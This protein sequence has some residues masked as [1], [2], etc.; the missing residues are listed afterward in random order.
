MSTAY[1]PAMKL[2][3]PEYNASSKGMG[4]LNTVADAGP[5]IIIL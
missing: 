4:P 1:L 2:L 5:S 3:A